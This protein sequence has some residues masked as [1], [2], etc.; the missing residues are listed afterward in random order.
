MLSVVMLSPLNSSGWI[1]EISTR[2]RGLSLRFITV[3]LISVHKQEKCANRGSGRRGGFELGTAPERR[4]SEGCGMA[5]LRSC[6]IERHTLGSIRTCAGRLLNRLVQDVAP[7]K[8][9]RICNKVK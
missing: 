7:K 4:V 8:R 6:K 9:E 2:L 1:D 5:V 3:Q